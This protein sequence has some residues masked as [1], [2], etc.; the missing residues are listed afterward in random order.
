MFAGVVF[1]AGLVELGSAIAL[2][3][4]QYEPTH[5]TDEL[6]RIYPGQDIEK[7]TRLLAELNR[8]NALE[9]APF[10]EFTTTPFKG[11]YVNVFPERYRSG[12][13]Q[14]WPPGNDSILIFGGSTTFGDG[15][16]DDETIPYYIGAKLGTDNVYNL[17]IPAYYSTIER[18]LFLNLLEQGVTPKAAV[19]IDGLND[20]IFHHFPDRSAF[21]NRLTVASKLDFHY[22]AMKLLAKLY[23]VRL[24]LHITGQTVADFVDQHPA[25]EADIHRAAIRLIQNRN[26][27]SAVC[28]QWGIECLFVTQPTATVFYDNGNRPVSVGNNFMGA[29]NCRIGY[30]ILEEYYRENPDPNHLFLARLQVEE[31]VYVD[32]FHYSVRMNQAMAHRIAIALKE[33]DI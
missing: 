11:R 28:K 30:P 2:K 8:S 6:R 32:R 33:R 22:M 27:I 25:S 19:F 31:P 24:I 15:T 9:Y 26:I 23:T 12:N 29:E 1:L 7:T 21:S 4:V 17:G 20:F 18:I 10:V 3:F 16:A 5:T 14:P 13:V